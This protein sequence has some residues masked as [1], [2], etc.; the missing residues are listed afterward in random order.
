MTKSAELPPP[1]RT[2]AEGLKWAE[3]MVR[4]CE[5][6]RSAIDAVDP[7]GPGTA[8]ELRLLERTY[9]LKH[10]AALGTV[11]TLLRTEKIG[12]EAYNEFVK[13]VRAT[14]TPSVIRSIR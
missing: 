5:D 8:R 11:G 6:A 4:E 12:P 3:E 7:D 10:G 9:L 13:R 14:L 1:I 2:E